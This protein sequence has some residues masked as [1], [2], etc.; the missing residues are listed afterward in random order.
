ME[1]FKTNVELDNLEQILKMTKQIRE[2]FK[3]QKYLSSTNTDSD[4]QQILKNQF[5][6]FS[7]NYPYLFSFL[8]STKTNDQL[9][10]K[11]EKTIDLK[12]QVVLGMISDIAGKQLALSSLAELRDN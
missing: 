2:E 6:D 12:R 4:I 9:V 8:C 11:M 10:Q 3:I 5:V 1:S 7:K